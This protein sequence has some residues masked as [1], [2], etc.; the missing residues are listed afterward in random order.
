M[1]YWTYEAIRLWLPPPPTY[2]LKPQCKRNF[3]AD[4]RSAIAIFIIL[5]TMVGISDFFAF[6]FFTHEE[7]KII[8]LQKIKKSITTCRKKYITNTEILEIKV[9]CYIYQI[10]QSFFNFSAIDFCSFFSTYPPPK[11]NYH[12]KIQ[13]SPTHFNIKRLTI[14]YV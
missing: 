10:Y 8:N 7:G 11:Q 1:V 14:K 4:M 12:S 2:Y 6:S 5:S 13:C 3:T 9:M